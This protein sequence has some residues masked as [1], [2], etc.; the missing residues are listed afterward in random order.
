MV[1]DLVHQQYEGFF[2]WQLCCYTRIQ[3]Q[4]E[5]SWTPKRIQAKKSLRSGK[6]ML[7]DWK[8]GVR[9]SDTLLPP[10]QKQ[11]EVCQLGVDGVSTR[12][13]HYNKLFTDVFD[14]PQISCFCP[15]SAKP[16]FRVSPKIA[17]FLPPMWFAAFA[18]VFPG[19]RCHFRKK[20]LV[21]FPIPSV[22]KQKTDW[23]W[24]NAKV[25][26]SNGYDDKS[27]GLL[28]VFNHP[29]CKI[30]CPTLG[31]MIVEYINPSVGWRTMFG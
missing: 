5:N 27:T 9:S 22:P 18:V 21:E 17:R 31:I 26:P 15:S 4:H 10:Q 30:S 11:H 24:M 20:K 2:C 28:S 16:P 6:S 23:C 14:V 13:W 8:V 29:N 25:W 3:T 12:S 1:L 7:V 19:E